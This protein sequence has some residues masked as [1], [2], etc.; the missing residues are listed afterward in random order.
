M[1]IFPPVSIKKSERFYS[2]ALHFA[3]NIVLFLVH[4]LIL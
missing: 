4:Y 1:Y 3:P 2:L